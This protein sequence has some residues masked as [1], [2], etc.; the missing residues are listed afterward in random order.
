M[1]RITIQA[2]LA[3]NSLAE[4]MV[5]YHQNMIKTWLKI[6]N[7]IK[8]NHNG[9][10]WVKDQELE[11]NFYLL[12]CFYCFLAVCSVLVHVFTI[13]GWSLKSLT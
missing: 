6:E 2:I 11:H 13:N 8:E 7:R 10:G 9:K 1:S 5:I 12:I 3:K 4:K